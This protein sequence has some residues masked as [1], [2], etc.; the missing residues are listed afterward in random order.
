MVFACQ[1]CKKSDEWLYTSRF[2][3]KCQ[4]IKHLLNLYGDD[5]YDTLEKVLVRTDTQQKSKIVNTISPKIER[6]LRSN[7]KKEEKCKAT[8]EKED[9]PKLKK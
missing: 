5:V 8:R 9:F 3:S 6:N 2:C 1:L 7:G 4:R